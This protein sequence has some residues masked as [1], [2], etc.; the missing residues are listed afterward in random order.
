MAG[1]DA[2]GENAEN[3]SQNTELW[4]RLLSHVHHRVAAIEN[5]IKITSHAITRTS[6]QRPELGEVKNFR[7]IFSVPSALARGYAILG[8][9][10]HS[11]VRTVRPPGT[12]LIFSQFRRLLSSNGRMALEIRSSS[13]YRPFSLST[14]KTSA[15]VNECA[16]RNLLDACISSEYTTLLRPNIFSWLFNS[17]YA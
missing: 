9:D 16:F 17:A 15:C 1:C 4:H 7:T 11:H 5:A 14:D 6:H 13:L 3:L 10:A 8:L 12:L 2:R